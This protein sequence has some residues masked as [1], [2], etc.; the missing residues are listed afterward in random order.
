MEHPL[1]MR[2]IELVGCRSHDL[3]D[4]KDDELIGPHQN[5]NF[6]QAKVEEIQQV[7]ETRKSYTS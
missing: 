3:W 1:V 5:L 4:I 7:T 2:Y 6:I